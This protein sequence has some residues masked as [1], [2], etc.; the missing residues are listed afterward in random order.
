ML[1]PQAISSAFLAACRAELAALKPGNVHDYGGG[2]NMEVADFERS[3]VAAAPHIADPGLGVGD[4]ILNA[5]T[6]TWQQVGCNTNLGIVL[7]TAPL[8]K[9]AELLPRSGSGTLGRE[10]AARQLRRALHDA[11]GGLTVADADATYRAIALMNPAGLGHVETADVSTPPA[12][13]LGAA[14][15]LAADRD[16]IASAYVTDFADVFDFALPEL[17]RAEELAAEPKLAI[18]TL[19]MALLARFADSHIARKHGLDAAHGVLREAAA[20]RACWQPVATPA[21]L[22]QLLGFDADLKTRRLNPGTTADFVVATLFAK[23]ITAKL[24]A[25]R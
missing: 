23:L 17:T 25:V 2:H 20:L 1:S 8:A 13:T 12:I 16:R 10:E 24:A 3:A 14:M 9:A 18:T 5:V 4:K 19:H 6:A 15:A 21:S 11:L 7:L 22:A